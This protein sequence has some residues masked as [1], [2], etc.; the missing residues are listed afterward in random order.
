[1]TEQLD[2]TGYYALGIPAY[3]VLLV[4]EHRW[5]RGRGRSGYRC[6]PTIG[7][8]S[9][10]LGEVIIGLFLGPC[11]VLLYGWAVERFA[12]VRWPEGSLTPW[13]LAFLLGDLGYYVY[14]RAGHS[15]A[16][17]WA[18]HSVHHQAE[19][20]DLT[21][22][23]R[24]PWF[25][26]FYS[27]P[28]YALLPLLGV[29]TL[30]FFIAISVISFYAVTIHSPIFRRPSLFVFVT[31]DTHV[32]HHAWNPPY[33]YRNFG[34][35]FTLWDRFFG[36]HVELDDATPARIG[37]RT[38]YETHDGALSQF[39]VFRSL[40]AAARRARTW[41]EVLAVFVGAP[42]R[43]PP[44]VMAPAPRRPARDDATIPLP[45]KLYAST[46]FAI[47]LALAV[48]VLW[49]R[50]RHPFS[51]LVA[52]AMVILVSLSTI[53][54]LLDGRRACVRD[55]MLRLAATAVLGLG[56]ARLWDHVDLG[57][58]ILAASITGAFT[59][60]AISR[61]SETA[62]SLGEPHAAEEAFLQ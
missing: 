57:L 23:L 39:V 5:A 40:L 30:H 31:P 17:L 44:G 19:D 4:I 10:G 18:V 52:S 46:Q 20:F 27:A 1:V 28:F 36:T 41:S 24:H 15:V 49:L 33:R 29:P 50:D 32:V 35:M 42:G 43:L 45:V 14:H 34:A 2:S 9:T 59:L 6:A 56:Y 53:G 11:L 25:S 22:A 61:T 37:V 26:D 12:L 21:L 38:G 54:G 3:L 51:L 13:V 48:F 47:T 7:T 62:R 8:L 55:E 58:A 16:C 60:A